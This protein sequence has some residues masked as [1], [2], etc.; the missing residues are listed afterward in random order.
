LKA[1][2]SLISDRGLQLYIVICWKLFL[3]II[4]VFFGLVAILEVGIRL[5]LAIG[6]Q[7]IFILI[8]IQSTKETIVNIRNDLN[9]R[10]EP[11]IVL[12]NLDN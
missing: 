7:S 3:F 9:S 8:V 10:K 4:I 6:L 5:Y 11:G 2:K 1:W 12:E